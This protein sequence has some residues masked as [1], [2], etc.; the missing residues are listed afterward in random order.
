MDTR[1]PF[2]DLIR[3]ARDRAGVSRLLARL[4][5]DPPGGTN[6][7]GPGG[8]GGPGDPNDPSDLDNPSD[9]GGD[10]LPRDAWAAYGLADAPDIRSL[11]VAGRSGSLDALLME[12]A[13]GTGTDRVAWLARRVRSRN[14]ARLHLFVAASPGYRRLVLGT[15]GL[16][17]A[18]R[19]LTLERAAIRPSD[20]EALEEMAP[21]NGERGLELAIRH[22]RALDRSRVTRAFFRDFRGRRGAVAEAWTGIPDDAAR[23]RAQL[24]LL[25][26]S[27]LT[28]LY[29]LQK[30]GALAGDDRYLVRLFGLWAG[31]RPRVQAGSEGDDGRTPDDAAGPASGAARQP[32]SFFRARLQPLFFGALNRRPEDRDPAARQLGDLPYLNGGLFERHALERRFPELDLPDDEVRACFDDLLERYRFTTREA[33]AGFGVDPEVLGRVFEGLMAPEARS[34]TGSFYTPAPVVDRVVKEAVATYVAGRVPEADPA[35][36]VEGRAAALPA[37]TRYRVRKS[38]ERVRVLD[39]ACGSGAFLLG[40][41]RRLSTAA[42]PL[43]DRPRGEIR[44]EI[45]ATGLHGVDLLDDAAL[46][47]SLRL[48][49]A[50]SEDDDRVRPLP[51]LDRRIRQGDALVDPLDLGAMDADEALHWHPLRHAD[52]RRALRALEPAARAYVASGP[53]ERALARDRVRRAEGRLARRWLDGVRGARERQLKQLRARAADRDLFGDVPEPARRAAAEAGRVER[54]IRELDGIARRLK[55]DD[56]L[57]FFSFAIHF[58]DAAGFDLVVSNPPWVRSHR[59]PGHLRKIADRFEVCR[60]PGWTAAAELTG[61]PVAGGGQ[62]DLSLLFV[63]RALRLLAPGGVLAVLVPAKCFRALYGAAA[64][65]ML[66]RDLEFALIE[67]H[68]LDQRAVFRADAFAGVL[69]GRAPASDTGRAAS[70]RTGGVNAA[71]PGDA[72]AARPG[73]GAPTAAEPDPRLVRVRMA[74]RGVAPLEFR[75]SQG[76]LP[77]FPDDPASPWLLAPPDVRAVLRRMQA[78][79]PPLG[80]HPGLRVRRGIMT[81][82]NDVLICSAEPKLGGL[83]EIEAEGYGRTRRGGASSRAAGKYRAVVETAGLRPLVRGADIDAFRYDVSGHVVWCHDERGEPAEPGPRLTS[84]LERHRDR[85][86]GRTGYRAGLPLGAVFRLAPETLGPKVAWHDLSDTLRAVALPAAVR[87]DGADRALVPLNTVYFLPTPDEE[88]GLLLAGLLNSLP[89]RAFARAVAERAKDARFRF[90]AWTLSTL[91][92]PGA[93]REHAAAPEIRAISAAAHRARGIPPADQVRLDRAVGALF[94]LRP[95]DLEHLGRFDR[96]LRGETVGSGTDSRDPAPEI[97]AG[98]RTA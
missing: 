29:F 78:A 88:A 90:F 87:S 55:E 54:R 43:S 9:P 20:I 65:R 47:C 52:T 41:L 94:G 34:D 70:G 35:V 27:R 3:G 59:W 22:A 53:E 91:P 68:A 18:F 98:R 33:G 84:Y 25:F 51:N 38:L 80:R 86:E 76:D 39:P 5:F 8:P 63:E 67:D 1:P 79:G 13:P 44:R 36:V 15:F 31:A 57:P 4:G 19:H 32:R 48:W 71:H 77:L 89:V 45:V 93:W 69:V 16:D 23:E 14:P 46:L 73:D 64:R 58:G 26:L 49:L 21:S 74:R 61:A 62:V 92:L 72:N 95:D 56:A 96:W 17:D 7:A 85:L 97:T 11:V 2:P 82:A 40:A 83:S 24:A 28:F 81:G 75:V 30:R 6:A 42:A 37:P 50:L 66:L 60:A 12:A 10:E